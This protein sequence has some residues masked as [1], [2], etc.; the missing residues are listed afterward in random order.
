MA[1]VKNG[2]LA[3]SSFV[4]VSGAD[5]IPAAG[6]V[7]VSFDQWKA[8]RDELLKRGTELGIRLHSDQ[9][10]ELIAEDLAH[11]AVVALEFPKFRDG[12]S[13][14]YARLLRERYGFKGELRAVG[15]VLLEQL[16]FM[17]RVGFD[18]FDIQSADPLKDYRTALADFSVW[19]QPTADGRKTA[20]Q[21]RRKR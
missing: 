4:D 7:I 2:E 10:P 5:A 11:F 16:F 1:L 13:Y 17:L 9:A 19:Y 3:T 12:R 14:S 21:L 18:A 20:M 8:H 6:P 15:E